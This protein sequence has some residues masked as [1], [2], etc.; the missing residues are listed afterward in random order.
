MSLV[1]LVRKAILEICQKKSN[2]QNRVINVIIFDD[3][4][5]AVSLA[6]WNE[7]VSLFI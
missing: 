5:Y 6:F 3:S 1:L 7:A 2:N 4:K